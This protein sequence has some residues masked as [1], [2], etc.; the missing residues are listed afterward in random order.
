MMGLTV[1]SI[2]EDIG[3]IGKALFSEPALLW[4]LAPII[5]VWIVLEVYFGRYAKEKLGWN[6]A[7]AN[8]I[9]LFWIVI[10]GMQYIF[11]NGAEKFSWVAFSII[12]FMAVYGLL[13]IVT[14]FKHSLPKNV[15]FA[16]ASPTPIYYFSAIVLLI[17]YQQILL[18]LPM[19]ISILALF[20]FF[21]VFFWIFRKLIPEKD[22][23]EID[24]DDDDYDVDTLDK[25]SKR[26]NK[27]ED[28]VLF[29]DTGNAPSFDD[30]FSSPDQESSFDD[31]F[32]PASSSSDPVPQNTS[33]PDEELRI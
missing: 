28:G 33:S 25:K 26:K 13:I 17:A 9:S 19:I 27:S 30:P 1:Q 16:I 6:T 10:S 24:S 8:G 29:D 32:S 12:A 11:A 21:Q 2:L 22:K 15:E 7:L 14:T 20:V 23:H 4:Q 5:L 18:D 31:D 3:G